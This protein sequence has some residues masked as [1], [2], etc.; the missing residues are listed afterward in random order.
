MSS[1]MFDVI[2]YDI[3]YIIQK[4][5]GDDWESALNFNLVLLPEER[6]ARRVF[7]KDEV[8]EHEVSAIV[9]SIKLSMD[10][11]ADTSISRKKRG[12][13]LLN[14]LAS[15]RKYNRQHI[16]ARSNYGFKNAVEE[17]CLDILVP[18]SDVIRHA[19]HMQKRTARKIAVKLLEDMITTVVV[20]TVSRQISVNESLP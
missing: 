8:R 20:P 16:I 1:T 13:Y 6:R 7:T 14:V 11:I 12:F 4:M 18:D 10:K 9:Q 15:F 19:T 17:K 5:L 2:P 3:I